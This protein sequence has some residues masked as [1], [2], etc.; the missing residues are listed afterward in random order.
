MRE[1]IGIMAATNDGVIGSKG[2]LP[3]NYPD[4]LEHFKSATL[5]QTIV[6][7]QKTY[8]S[9]P[10][11]LFKNRRALVLSRSSQ[12]QLEDA[13]VLYSM[14][15]F[16][17]YMTTNPSMAKIFMIG[18]GEIANLFLENNLISSFILTQIHKAYAGDTYM[19]LSYLQGWPTEELKKTKNYTIYLLNNPK[20]V[21]WNL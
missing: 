5:N 12:L 16:V 11:D 18:G 17:G 13:S 7:G 4:E 19:N 3:W 10:K 9:T 14:D 1:I 6:M 20:E 2:K 15:E 8:E 21:P